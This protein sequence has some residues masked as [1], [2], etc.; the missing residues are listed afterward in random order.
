MIF[1]IIF[2][3]TN[4]RHHY[5]APSID[6]DKLDEAFVAFNEWFDAQPQGTQAV[7]YH[8]I[9]AMYTLPQPK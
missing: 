6:C 3:D 9:N 4:G 7:L 2:I 5:D 1:D 8:G